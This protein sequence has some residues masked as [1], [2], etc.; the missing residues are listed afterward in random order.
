MFA[1]VVSKHHSNN[2]FWKRA[3]K[4]THSETAQCFYCEISALLE[5]HFVVIFLWVHDKLTAIRSPEFISLHLFGWLIKGTLWL[6]R[7]V[8]S[9]APR[10]SISVSALSYFNLSLNFMMGMKDSLHVPPSWRPQHASLAEILIDAPAQWPGHRKHTIRLCLQAS[11]PTI[12]LHSEEALHNLPFLLLPQRRVSLTVYLHA[13]CWSVCVHVS[14]PQS[15]TFSQPTEGHQYGSPHRVNT[16]L[17][18]LTVICL[19][20]RSSVKAQAWPVSENRAVMA[21]VWHLLYP[22]HETSNAIVSSETPS[23]VKQL[24]WNR[25]SLKM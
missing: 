22:L 5:P 6:S 14:Y 23:A 19:P 18:Q 15:H 25:P 7:S 2:H 12:E 1:D 4:H 17:N 8:P 21:W 3:E 24:V 11:R 9:H 13:S 20:Y 16:L 10:T